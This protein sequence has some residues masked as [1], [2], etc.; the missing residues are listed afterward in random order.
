LKSAAGEWKPKYGALAISS[1]RDDWNPTLT[2]ES[3]SPVASEH[4]S[5]PP[6]TP[7]SLDTLQQPVI[8]PLAPTAL[9]H[10]EPPATVD[11]R[12]PYNPSDTAKTAPSASS[13]TAGA[14]SQRTSVTRLT[15]D[16]TLDR[17]LV[18]A[19]SPLG[20]DAVQKL[21]DA[22]EK[23]SRGYP[24]PAGRL[25]YSGR[26]MLRLRFQMSLQTRRRC[27]R[28]LT[29]ICGEYTILPN[30]YVI[31]QSKIQKMGD[32]PISSRDFFDVWSGMKSDDIREIKT[33]GYFDVFSSRP[34][35]TVRRTF[36]ERL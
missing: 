23:V 11:S 4:E 24:L 18:R 28:A 33:V 9:Y 13:T 16:E 10:P 5:D 20:E 14:Q 15:P 3:D 31:P 34:N 27:L 35:L 12:T 17:L 36:S 25:T 6:T 7:A 8:K 21:V 1:P 29:N 2:E 26:Q 19:K 32:S 22:L 30:S